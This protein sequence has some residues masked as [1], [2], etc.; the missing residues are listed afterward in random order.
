MPTAPDAIIFDLGGVLV[1]HD[2]DLMFSRLAEVFDRRPG[3]DDVLAQIRS[4]RIGVGA[5]TVSDLYAEL[6]RSFGVKHGKAEWDAAWC[7]HF[8]P[9]TAMLDWLAGFRGPRLAI[10][11]NTNAEH[12]DHI[13]R[14]Y[15]PSRLVERVFLSHEIGSEKPDPEIYRHVTAEMGLD[16]TR[17]LFV[18]DRAENLHAAQALGM[19]THLYDRHDAF[20]ADLRAR[21]L[22]A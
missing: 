9:N 18:D 16:P 19:S 21:G 8:A 17:T 14:E 5:Q 7:C 1:F 20:V 12:W 11:S 6:A 10:C 2:N 15:R 22:P 3:P 4:S 13:E